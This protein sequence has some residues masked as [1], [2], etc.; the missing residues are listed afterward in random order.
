[1][2]KK[3]FQSI[4]KYPCHLQLSTIFLEKYSKKDPLIVYCVLEPRSVLAASRLKELGFENVK[5]L[6]SDFKNWSEKNYPISK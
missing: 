1:M 2:G 3:T 4:G 6:K 5:Y